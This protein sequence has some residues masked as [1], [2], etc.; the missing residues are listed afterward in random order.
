MERK[1]LSFRQQTA[2]QANNLSQPLMEKS[3]DK[4]GVGSRRQKELVFTGSSSVSQWSRLEASVEI[5]LPGDNVC[6]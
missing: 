1:A 3:A 5:R 6:K 4:N 2:R